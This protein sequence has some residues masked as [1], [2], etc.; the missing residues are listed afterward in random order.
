MARPRWRAHGHPDSS[1]ARCG[2][3]QCVAMEASPGAR[4]EVGMVRQRRELAEGGAR[5]QRWQ[6]WASDGGLTRGSCDGRAFIAEA[7][8]K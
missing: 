6:R 2:G 7:R 1:E 3:G 5:L 8:E 4:E